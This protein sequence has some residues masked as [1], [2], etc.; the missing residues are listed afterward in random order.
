MS[1]EE[2]SGEDTKLRTAY[3]ALRGGRHAAAL[4]LL[5]GLS[6]PDRPAAA[7][8]VA[9]F[10]AQALDGLGR[11]P[12][13]ERAAAASVRLARAAGDDDGVATTRALHA[14]LLASL[15]ATESATRAR[16][17]DVP[18][19]DTPDDLL[20][21]SAAEGTP[22][23]SPRAAILIRKANALADAQ[24]TDEALRTARRAE[25][26]ARLAGDPRETVFAL[27]CQLRVAP[28]DATPL[29]HRAHAVADAADDMNLITAVARAARAAGVVLAA[30]GFI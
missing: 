6:F 3:A 7:A 29:L 30:P 11:L 17:A 9:S 20:L 22:G 16:A 28:A 13:A 21:A 26:E 23:T 15:A 27:L 24:R 4:A 12:E 18:L 10:R 1:G 25:E 2:G 5:D 14:R 8:R 19:A